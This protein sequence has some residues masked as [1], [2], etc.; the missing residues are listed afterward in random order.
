M[1]FANGESF[2]PIGSGH[3][4]WRDADRADEY[5]TTFSTFGA[6]GINLVRIW[7]QSDGFKLTTEGHFDAYAYPNL[8]TWT[9]NT[10]QMQSVFKYADLSLLLPVFEQTNSSYNLVGTTQKVYGCRPKN[11]KH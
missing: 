10:P 8:N 5:V 3:Q 6:N 1:E 4:W 11:L 7:D 2:I 9:W